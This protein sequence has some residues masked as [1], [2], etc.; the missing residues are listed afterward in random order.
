MAGEGKGV[1]ER[2][3]T[4]VRILAYLGQI[5][6]APYHGNRTRFLLKPPLYEGQ[7]TSLNEPC[8]DASVILALHQQLQTESPGLLLP[9]KRGPRDSM[10]GNQPWCVLGA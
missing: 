1:E 6:E 2:A 9:W 8:H 5:Q 10:Q 4:Y 7:S 3:R